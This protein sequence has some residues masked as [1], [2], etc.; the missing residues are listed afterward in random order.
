[1]KKKFTKGYKKLIGDDGKIIEVNTHVSYKNKRTVFVVAVADDDTL[2]VES[3]GK[4]IEVNFDDVQPLQN[5]VSLPLPTKKEKPVN[6]LQNENERLRREL[7]ECHRKLNSDNITDRKV[8]S[9]CKVEV[10][11]IRGK[12]TI[13]IHFS[14]EPPT[15]VKMQIK[16]QGFSW[17]KYSTNEPRTGKGNGYWGVF[18]NDKRYEFAKQ[19]CKPNSGNENT[20]LIQESPTTSENRYMTLP[21]VIDSLETKQRKAIEDLRLLM[22]SKVLR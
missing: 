14:E 18:Y 10:V 13:R 11:T 5:I 17:Y 22:K 9:E 3:D 1:M 6:S 7:E 21:P 4:Q 8:Y 19:F 16:K 12:K 20:P 2:L 15:D